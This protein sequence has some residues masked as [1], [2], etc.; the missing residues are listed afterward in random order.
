MPTYILKLIDQ[1]EP[2]EVVADSYNKSSEMIEFFRRV[3]PPGGSE[4]HARPKLIG[5][6]ERRQVVSCLDK[7]LLEWLFA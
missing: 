2:E 4:E 3:I 1:D 6:Y 7:E 5:W